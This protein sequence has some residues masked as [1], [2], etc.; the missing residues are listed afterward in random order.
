MPGTPNRKP[1]HNRPVAQRPQALK[2]PPG[3][4]RSPPRVPTDAPARATTAPPRKKEPA[5]MEELIPVLVRHALTPDEGMTVA[6]FNDVFLPRVKA[7]VPHSL[8]H[9]RDDVARQYLLDMA[10]ALYIAL[11]AGTFIGRPVLCAVRAA[12]LGADLAER[13][14]SDIEAREDRRHQ[15]I[16]CRNLLAGLTLCSLRALESARLANQQLDGYTTGFER[17]VK[18]IYGIKTQT[19]AAGA[20]PWARHA[21][22]PLEGRI[23]RAIHEV[24][25]AFGEYIG[26]NGSTMDEQQYE[27]VMREFDGFMRVFAPVIDGNAQR[28][29]P[30]DSTPRAASVEPLNIDGIT[31]RPAGIEIQLTDGRVLFLSTEDARRIGH[32]A[33]ASAE[34]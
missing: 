2:R 16:R 29:R 25:N 23:N 12:E 22:K 8:R 32:A 28:K 14:L 33:D 26:T 24:S 3:P 5:R 13:V 31:T 9:M 20:A 30:G 17:A 18:T 1:R 19:E 4:K 6:R 27:L 15:A 34:G 21:D 10:H 7:L 11:V